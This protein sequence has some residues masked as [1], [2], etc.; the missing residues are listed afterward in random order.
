MQK[1]EGIKE[2]TRAHHILKRKNQILFLNCRNLSKGLFVNREDFESRKFGNSTR[3]FLNFNFSHFSNKLLANNGCFNNL[4]YLT[5]RKREFLTSAF[6]QKNCESSK[7]PVEVSE[8]SSNIQDEFIENMKERKSKVIE[9]IKERKSQVKEKVSEVIEHE[10]IWTIP[11]ILCI[12]RIVISP[13]IFQMILGGEYN[14]ALG[15]FLLAGFTDI[16]DGWIARKWPGQSTRLGSFLDP[17]ADKVLVAFV[18]LSLTIN[19]LIPVPLTGLIIYRDICIIAGA[20]WVRFKSL[21]PPRTITR[22]F[23]A[24]H[25][26]AQLAPTAISKINT[27]VQLGLITASLA[28]PVFHFVDNTALHILWGVTAVTTLSSGISYIFSNTTYTF[29]KNYEKGK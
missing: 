5:P 29:L 21:P 9:E 15:L 19:G 10:N 14:T 18:F 8:H 26:T 17:L 4:M 27:A 24:T 28:A 11:N 13:V 25:A 7:S 2:L 12:G 16:L 3:P 6:L 23:D 22:Y 20:S 1:Y